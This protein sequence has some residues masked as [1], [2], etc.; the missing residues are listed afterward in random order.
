METLNAMDV[1]E[2]RALGTLGKRQNPRVNQLPLD[3]T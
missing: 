2:E 3:I 1:I